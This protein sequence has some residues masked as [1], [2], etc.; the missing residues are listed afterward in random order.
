M[1]GGVDGVPEVFCSAC[2]KRQ[3][4]AS[5]PH[6]EHIYGAEGTDW[7]ELPRQKANLFERASCFAKKCDDSQ[8]A[9]CRHTPYFPTEGG[10]RQLSLSEENLFLHEQIIEKTLC[11]WVESRTPAL[12]GKCPSGLEGLVQYQHAFLDEE[13]EKVHAAFDCKMKKGPGG[14]AHDQQ[15]RNIR[16][17]AVFVPLFGA[18]LWIVQVHHFLFLSRRVVLCSYS[19]T[20]SCTLLRLHCTYLHWNQ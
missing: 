8:K 17:F 3:R 15:S 7:M 4:R 9:H 11:A 19:I 6:I 1:K 13:L 16:T 20:N 18:V 5:S 12:T 14:D 2:K 10:V